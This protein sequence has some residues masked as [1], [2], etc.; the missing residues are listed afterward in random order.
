MSHGLTN[1]DSMFSVR[2]MPWHGLGV[3]LD[4]YPRSIDEALDRA[5]LG[6][7]VIHGDV[8]VVRAPEWTDDFGTK[9]VAELTPAKGFTA[10]VREDTVEVLG[11]VLGRVRGRR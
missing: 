4:D 9:H 6:W 2:E 1:H 7:K 10:N 3:V 5:G 8:L 11:I